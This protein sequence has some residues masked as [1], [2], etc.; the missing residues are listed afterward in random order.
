MPWLQLLSH[1]LNVVRQHSAGSSTNQSY[2]RVMSPV[3][4]PFSVYIS[5][6]LI[7]SEVSSAARRTSPREEVGSLLASPAEVEHSCASQI[8]QTLR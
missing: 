7:R 8:L 1:K 5:G 2:N 3:Y 4:H 6:Y